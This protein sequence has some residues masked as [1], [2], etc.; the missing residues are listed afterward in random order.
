MADRLQRIPPTRIA[1]WPTTDA[2]H[3]S[4]NPCSELPGWVRFTLTGWVSLP[5]AMTGKRPMPSASACHRSDRPRAKAWNRGETCNCKPR[6]SDRFCRLGPGLTL[7]TDRSVKSIVRSCWYFSIQPKTAPKYQPS[8]QQISRTRLNHLDLLGKKKP[9]RRLILRGFFTFLDLL[10]TILG[11]QRGIRTPDT[12]LTYT[13]FP[14]VRLQPLGHLSYC[15]FRGLLVLL[16][17]AAENAN[18]RF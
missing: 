1:G 6:P 11:G 12:L 9:R 14:G 7:R 16:K 4:V 13:R 10:G 2:N 5:S 15:I 18:P 17:G 3:A 8:Y